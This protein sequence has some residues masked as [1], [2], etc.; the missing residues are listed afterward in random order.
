MRISDEQVYTGTFSPPKSFSSFNSPTY[1]SPKLQAGPPLLFAD[2]KKG[3]R[4]VPLG[5]RKYLFIDDSLMANKENVTLTVN[6]PRF[7]ERVLNDVQ[8]HLIVWGMRTGLSECITTSAAAPGCTHSHD[9]I[10]WE[11]LT[12]CAW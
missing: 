11:N 1:E 10:H 7:A 4:V 8:G 9:G 12:T 5:G 6:P 2:E 3:D